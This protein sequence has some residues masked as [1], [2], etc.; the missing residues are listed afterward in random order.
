MFGTSPSVLRT[1][2]VMPK[3]PSPRSRWTT[4]VVWMRVGVKP[5]LGEPVGEGHRE[6]AGVGGRDQL[7]GVA[8]FTSSKR[9][10]NE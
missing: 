3:P 8:A 10:T 6:A 5:G 9:E 4:A 7:L 1:I 2:F